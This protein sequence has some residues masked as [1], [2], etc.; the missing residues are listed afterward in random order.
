MA[1]ADGSILIRTKVDTNGIKQGTQSIQ[2]GVGK[3][4]AS[5]LKL[6]ATML[7]VFSVAK[8]VQFGKEAISL[9]S[10]LQEVQNVVDVAFGEMSYKIEQF[11]DTAIENFGL[12]ELSAK[13]M[14]STF[15]AM[16]N[17]MKQGLDVA[18]DMAV[19][20]TGRLADI[21]SFYN[22]SISEVETIGRAVYS[23]ETEPLKQIGVIMTE[24]QLQ[25]FALAQGYSTLY[26]NMS[27]ADKLFIRQLYFLDTTNQAAGDFVRTQSSWAN[28]TRILSERWKEFLSIVGSR[29]IQSL[30]PVVQLMN[31]MLTVAINLAN[32]M[33][34]IF[35]WQVEQSNAT[36]TTSGY[37]ADTADS[38]SE[39]GALTEK[40]NKALKKQLAYFDDI[41]VL[42]SESASGSG[43][44]LTGGVSTGGSLI[45]SDKTVAELSK[46]ETKMLEF[47]ERIKTA[48][49]TDADFTF[50]GDEIGKAVNGMLENIDWETIKT[51]SYKLGK[52]ISTFLNGSI[53]ETDWNLIGETLAEGLNT[54]I[55][56]AQGEIENFDF[57]AFG[58]A[59]GDG[60]NGFFETADWE[61]LFSNGS[62]LVVGLLDTVT[63]A[64]EETDF[65]M[66]GE[67]IANGLEEVDWDKIFINLGELISAAIGG[68]I[69]LLKGI[70]VSSE[71]ADSSKSELEKLIPD[72]L[73]E[74]IQIGAATIGLDIEYAINGPGAIP[75]W[76]EEE[77]PKATL[78]ITFDEDGWN[79][80]I[81]KWLRDV[82][83]AGVTTYGLD[84]IKSWGEELG[85]NITDGIDT[86]FEDWTDAFTTI[87]DWYNESIAVWFTKTKWKTLG[88]QI[89]SGLEDGLGEGTEPIKAVINIMI[90]MMNTFIGGVIG[91]IN[92]IITALNSLKVTVP[93]W[94][95]VA[96]GFSGFGFDIAKLSEF[97]IP[98]LA[99][100]GVI[101][102]NKE[103]MA[104]LG[105]QKSGTNIEAPLDT[106]KQALMEVLNGRGNV[107]AQSG[108]LVVKV[109]DTELIRVLLPTLLSEMNRQG[110]DT[111]VL[112]AV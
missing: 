41:N 97:K 20:M 80:S 89:V 13:T 66:I 28:Q 38:E 67:E 21:M 58:T 23:G 81:P 104:V 71:E 74:W 9:A 22:K 33:A 53:K 65:E 32:A 90:E 45:N 40:T 59:I 73:W 3:I 72:T 37:V 112:G 62:D 14:A 1:S 7:A 42:S 12:S 51:N 50:I 93:D 5:L 101:P 108:D 43:S 2:S 85:T 48:W 57:D 10:D 61:T 78:G 102:P 35:G 34:D 111:T 87:E 52:S 91:G 54:F 26:K 8:L 46:L 17:G 29:L 84:S 19:Q 103:F 6:G 4:N 82:L 106:I 92:A 16:A 25:T 49:E 30:T 109:G 77:N 83:T 31:N 98:K 11:A 68:S 55:E 96:T 75:W 39:L 15:M 86:A 107:S 105:D 56:F 88:S 24:A 94:V 36:A 64:L 99:Q 70:Q 47:L 63:A 27:A 18:S 110:Y 100:G 95:T 60:I 79:S 76:A 44:G 69:D